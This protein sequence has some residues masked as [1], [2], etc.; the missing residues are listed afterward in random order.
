MRRL[1]GAALMAAAALAQV[2]WAPHLEVAGA[3]PNLVLLGVVGVTWTHGQ[4]A[5]MVWACV[6]G[7]LLDLVASGPIGPHAIALLVAAY[8]VGFW[9]RDLERPAAVHVVLTA[10]AGTVLYSAVL[11]LT[12]GL[13]GLPVPQPGT[14]MWL[15]FTAAVYNALLMPLALE[16]LRRL[17]AF[18]RSVPE[19]T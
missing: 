17:Q 4:R 6:G 7:L 1:A 14:A 10:A 19:A 5:G 15:A 8:A 16:V 9:T 2:T 13:L 11:V 12:G 18:T 3:F